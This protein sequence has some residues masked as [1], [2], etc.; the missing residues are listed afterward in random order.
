MKPS[1]IIE[2]WKNFRNQEGYLQRVDP[3]HPLDFFVGISI[4]GKDELVLITV[5]EPA[6]LI[7]S[8]ALEIEKK[9]RQDK[10]WATQICST[11]N[12]NRD[13]FAKLCVDLIESSRDVKNEIEG[14]NCVAKR[15]FAWQRLLSS[16]H[17][18][19]P[20]SVLKGLIGELSFARDVLS[21]RYSMDDIISA[22]QGPD[23]ADRDYIFEN[24]WFEIKSISTG[25]D[26]ITISSLNQLEVDTDGYI[27]QFF[28][29]ESSS[30]DASAIS[31]FSFIENIRK[32]LEQNPSAYFAFEQKL[33]N[34]GYVDK[35]AYE[36]IYFTIH[37]PRYFVVD[38]SFPKLT[39][40]SVPNG[41]IKAKYDVS[42]SC[43]AEYE[44]AENDIW[45]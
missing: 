29:D 26:E 37:G 8:K 23:G 18:V 20:I 6:Q 42:L 11:E 24:T 27:V 39:T 17:S 9:K 2:K 5:N 10:K 43:V 1:E 44:R 16:K 41:I 19:L 15:F 21:K 12:E 32:M 14:I 30:T 35:K 33:V 7:S 31:V 28:V 4:N 40:D 34:L 22:W 13:I 38:N 45:R 25:K 3:N 36:E